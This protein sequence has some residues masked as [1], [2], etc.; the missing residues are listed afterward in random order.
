MSG[1]ADGSDGDRPARQRPGETFAQLPQR[2]RTV[3]AAAAMVV[4]V[5]FGFLLLP[6]GVDVD[7]TRVECGSPLTPAQ[8]DP[9]DP[10]R[11]ACEDVAGGRQ[12]V[13]G[14]VVVVTVIAAFATRAWLAHRDGNDVGMV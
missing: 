2:Q 10:A 12:A 14:V 4:M 3:V 7:G 11:Q 6:F 13:A 9:S 8:L 5:A 1:S